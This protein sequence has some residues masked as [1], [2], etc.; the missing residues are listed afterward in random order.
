[1][2]TVDDINKANDYR[3]FWWTLNTSPENV[4]RLHRESATIRGWRHGNL[5][6]V[7][8]ALPGAAEYPKPHVLSLVQDEATPS[9]YR[10]LPQPRRR[11]GDYVRPGEMV[12][13][14]VFVR[15]RLVAKVA[16]YNGRFMSVMIPRRKGD[17]SAAVTRLESVPNSLA[18]RI[19]FPDVEDTLIFAY[20]HNLLE[21]ADVKARGRWCVVRRDRRTRRVLD[22]ELGEGTSLSVANRRLGVR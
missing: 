21:A 18:M 14:I 15:P 20:E 19:A 7:H 3:E 6:D 12:N 5:L 9:S 1:V 10:Y 17:D 13:G 4:I 2:W 16:G 22:Y 8:F 11:V